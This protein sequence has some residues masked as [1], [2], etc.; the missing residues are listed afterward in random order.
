M[1]LKIIKGDERHHN[2]ILNSWLNG[3]YAQ[4]KVRPSKD[5]FFKEHQALIK[6][7]LERSSILVAV[8][9]EDEDTFFGYLVHNKSVV[10]WMSVK[11][12]YQKRGIATALVNELGKSHLEFSHYTPAV[13]FFR[14][15]N[16]SF[17]PY[18]FYKE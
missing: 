7:C 4:S 15:F 2:F 12:P 16:L 10:H 9:E 13:G 14:K 5:I 8:F 18:S 3:Y 17:N 11:T 1:S 6:K